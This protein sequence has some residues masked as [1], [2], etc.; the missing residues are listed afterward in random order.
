MRIC[1]S[2]WNQGIKDVFFLGMYYT[3]VQSTLMNNKSLPD[4][5]NTS[6]TLL[7]QMNV[8]RSRVRDTRRHH[9]SPK[10]SSLVRHRLF[11]EP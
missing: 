8:P 6:F 4:L 2:W 3:F 10:S 11:L 7:N 9:R 1:I 5:E